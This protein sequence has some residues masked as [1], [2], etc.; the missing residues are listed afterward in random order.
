MPIFVRT[1]DFL[2]WLLPITNSFPRAHRFSVT[3][4][5]LDATFDLYE[6]LEEANHRRGVARMARL[7]EADEALDKVRMY[8]RLAARWNWLSAGQY[9]HAAAMVAE[10]GRLLGGWQKATSGGDRER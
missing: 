1:F 10:I 2:T 3:R 7:S 6:A 4:R 5:L 8:L 9:R